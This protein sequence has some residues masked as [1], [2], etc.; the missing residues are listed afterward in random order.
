MKVKCPW[1]DDNH[2]IPRNLASMELDGTRLV[3]CLML[4][5]PKAFSFFFF[6]T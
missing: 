5:L 2:I 4:S 3:C 6:S 1:T